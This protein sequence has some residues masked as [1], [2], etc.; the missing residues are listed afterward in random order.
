MTA[1]LNPTQSLIYL[2]Y[3]ATTP[4]DRRVLEAMLPYFQ[5]NFGNPSSVHRFGQRAEAAL[6]KESCLETICSYCQNKI[7]LDPRT[8]EPFR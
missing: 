8:F 6:E 2:D 5:E 4:V 1:M 7:S 3:A